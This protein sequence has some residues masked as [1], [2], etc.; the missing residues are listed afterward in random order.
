MMSVVESGY[1]MVCP[2][3]ET[4]IHR[5]GKRV[6]DEGEE[7]EGEGE[8]EDDVGNEATPGSERRVWR[9]WFVPS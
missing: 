8:D 5:D 3:D 2:E 9:P 7:G 1:K 6:E 4:E